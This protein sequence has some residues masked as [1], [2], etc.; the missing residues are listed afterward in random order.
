MEELGVGAA[1]R[2]GGVEVGVGEEIF[3]AIGAGFEEA[4]S[5]SGKDGI[6]LVNVVEHAAGAEIGRVRVAG[7]NGDRTFAHG[8]EVGDFST[9]GPF[10]DIGRGPAGAPLIA[11]GGAGFG[12][13]SV[14]GEEAGDDDFGAGR[15][16]EGDV[17]FVVR[18]RV[19]VSRFGGLRTVKGE[20][21]GMPEL[22]F[23]GDFGFGDPAGG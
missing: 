21:D 22:E 9:V 19:W 14:G 17:E 5:G 10:A 7:N 2:D 13:V 6:A 15:R 11:A 16:G 3:G 23:P 18:E 8:S 20:G 1:L 12:G 4:L